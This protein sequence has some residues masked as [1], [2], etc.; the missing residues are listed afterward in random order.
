MTAA[1]KPGNGRLDGRAGRVTSVRSLK[2]P[3]SLNGLPVTGYVYKGSGADEI[4]PNHGGPKQKPKPGGESATVTFLRGVLPVTQ[5]D[6]VRAAEIARRE[7][8]KCPD[9]KCRQ[10]KPNH[11]FT[12]RA[13]EDGPEGDAA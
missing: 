5:L 11:L 7:A 8:T 12:C 2:P 9:P 10:L 4:T 3:K 6:E 1:P 13:G